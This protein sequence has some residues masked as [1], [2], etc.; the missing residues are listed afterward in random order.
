MNVLAFFFPF[1]FPPFLGLGFLFYFLPSIIALAHS[2][3]NTL[4]I[5]LLNLFFG[6][7][8]IG[9]IVALIWAAKVDVPYLVVR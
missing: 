6:W 4:A 9:W 2:K 1:L 3:R 5:F 7:T 8:F